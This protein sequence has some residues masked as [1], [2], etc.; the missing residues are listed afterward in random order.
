MQKEM[1]KSLGF[2]HV[3]AI[4][5][6][7][8]ISSGIFILPGLAF[9]RS[10][11]SVILAYVLAGIVAMAGIL[12]LVELVT[13]MPK[14]GGDY[15]IIHRSLG[16]LVGTVAGML[17]WFA[18][19]LKSAFAVVG[20]SEISGVLV[21]IS[22]HYLAVGF[23]L[24][25]VVINLMGVDF[26]SKLEVGLVVL[27]L[28]LLGAYAFLGWNRVDPEAYRPF[29][30]RGAQGFVSTIAFVFVSFGGLINVASIAEEVRNPRRN[31]PLGI[32]LSVAA[33]TL[34]Y[35]AVLYVTVGILPAADLGSSLRPLAD[36]GRI[37]A[38]G[39]GFIALNIAAVLAFLTTANAGLLSAARYPMALS[40][41][42]LLPAFL[43]RTKG[44]VPI[45]ALLLTGLLM[46]GA[47]FLPLD[48]LVKSASAVILTTYI[49]TNLSVL[50]LRSGRVLNYRP[51]FRAPLY[52][53]LQIL[54]ILIFL[55][56]IID[57]GWVSIEASLGFVLL[58]L[59]FYLFYGRKAA[60]REYALL[61]WVERI[62]N[63]RFTGH[64]LEEE[65]REI[66]RRRDGIE[67]DDFDRLLREAVVLD[68]D[69]EMAY[70]E[71]FRTV[72]ETVSPELGIRAEELNAALIEREESS[73]TVLDDFLAVPHII[74]PGEDRF[75]LT[76]VR[77]RRGVRFS[78]EREQVQAVFFLFGSEDR[79]T[80]HLQVLSILAR[81]VLTQGFRDSWR[82][83]TGPEQL[84]DLLLMG[85]RPRYSN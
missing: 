32:L 69:G 59:L 81:L 66:V 29:F 45:P 75:R 70:S 51:S 18:L 62:V 11:P 68:L 21:G 24:L 46:G 61:H 8:M 41:D 84:R 15:F 22:P 37:L 64:G 65:L 31:I 10:G 5:S 58:S 43:G 54:S 71:L 23:T 17:T 79:R 3:F 44:T 12:S 55:G 13:A 82:E 19:T 36:T 76:L 49:L 25:F 77:G 60:K 52:P 1:P 14:S 50:V 20:L 4:A 33:I 30:S 53:F 42:R 67:D 35:G 85:E 28:G 57:L 7:V 16:S 72:A 34:I 26:A 83:A 80:L 78:P 6:G 38:G 27:L 74:I 9:E 56:L 39:Y 63:K 73:S 48:L 47:I 2:V 40:S